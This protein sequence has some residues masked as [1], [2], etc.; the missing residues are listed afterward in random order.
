M[1]MALNKHVYLWHWSPSCRTQSIVNEGL[2]RVSWQG[3]KLVSY[4]ADLRTAARLRDH[5]AIRHGE[6]LYKM[7]GWIVRV[8][9]DRTVRWQ[10]GIYLI[11]DDVDG[12]DLCGPFRYTTDPLV[13]RKNGVASYF[14]PER[15]IS[16][17]P[18][19]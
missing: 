4:A 17:Q 7:H 2:R 9:R 18:I 12:A 10:G 1:N 15:S 13:V 16:C 5:C 8:L 19:G 6:S 11:L 3:R 14:A